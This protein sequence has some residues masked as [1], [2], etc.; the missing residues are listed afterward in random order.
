[1]ASVEHAEI[2]ADGSLGPWSSTT[3][4]S[5]PKEGCAALWVDGV[6][7]V[8]GGSRQGVYLRDVE[9][10]WVNQAGELGYWANPSPPT[11]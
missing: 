4:L 6:I 1:M 2:Q 9:L 11:P 7:Y 3:P 8:I 10:G 5:T